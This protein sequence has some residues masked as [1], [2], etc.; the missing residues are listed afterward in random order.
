MTIAMLEEQMKIEREKLNQIVIDNGLDMSCANVIRQSEIL[1]VIL[2]KL[3][4]AYNK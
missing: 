1:D 3:M 4:I 2:T